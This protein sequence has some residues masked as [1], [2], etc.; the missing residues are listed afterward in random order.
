LGFSIAVKAT[1]GLELPSTPTVFARL[2]SSLIRKPISGPHLSSTSTVSGARNLH[3]APPYLVEE[4]FIPRA[5]R[6]AY[7]KPELLQRKRALAQSSL[8]NCN[9]CPR[10]C[11]ANRF[12]K[13]G[14]C[15]I[16]EKATVDVIAPHFG[17]ETCLV[18]TNGSGTLF[19]SG[20][21]LRGMGRRGEKRDA[22]TS[23]L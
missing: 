10:K 2:A 20:C 15:L 17:E 4:P 18:G 14:V 7:Q 9:M 12:L 16:G 11:G 8:S 1:S 13:P 3:L 21:S 6:L 5:Q 22:R 19:F 23:I